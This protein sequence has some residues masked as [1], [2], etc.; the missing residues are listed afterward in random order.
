MLGNN[1][2][3]LRVEAQKILD[4]PGRGT[5]YKKVHVHCHSGAGFQKMMGICGCVLH[6]D[7]PSW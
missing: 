7:G 5:L 4:S 1:I 6:M 2:L 3:Q